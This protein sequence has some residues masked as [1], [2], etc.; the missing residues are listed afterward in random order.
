MEDADI[1]PDGNQSSGNS[2]V[3]SEPEEASA[4]A[5]ER[6]L[7]AASLARRGSRVA[8]EASHGGSSI[9]RA[10]AD[11]D[12]EHYD[13][14]DEDPA[15]G[16][17]GANP[18]MAA[19]K[20]PEKDPYFEGARGGAD[21][22][23]SDSDA[24]SEAGALTLQENDRLI[25]AVRNEDDVS[26]LEMWVYE[27]QD[28][29]GPANLFVHHSVLLPAFPLA[30]AWL[31]CNPRGGVAPG[32]Y[33]AVA[34]YEPGIELWDLD[35]VD[36]VEPVATLGGADYAAARDLQV[37]DIPFSGGKKKSKGKSKNKGA[38]EVAVR[39]GS[40]EDAVLGLSWNRLVRN[41]LAS[42][43]AD[44]TVKVWD[45]TTQQATNTLKHHKDK[46]QAVAWNGT[47]A[48]VLLTGGFDKRACL[49]R[50]GGVWFICHVCFAATWTSSSRCLASNTRPRW[51]CAR[52]SRCRSG[53]CRPT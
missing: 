12:M 21:D 10:L 25:L 39:P 27:P 48:S 7:R 14:S 16:V 30:V 42:G 15:M 2:E 52:Q 44:E 19:L 8:G 29:R 1:S 38:P 23:G 35:V 41:V 51:T 45:V 43:S 40:H 6:A 22:A 5:S 49:V 46:V 37:E 36:A 24:D 4:S 53:S 32:N 33:C 11:L 47:E 34:S 9:E 13:D 50:G 20:H 31:D 3:D 17:L 18:G 26:H 28:A